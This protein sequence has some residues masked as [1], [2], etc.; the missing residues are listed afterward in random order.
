MPASTFSRAGPDDPVP[1]IQLAGWLFD[2][3]PKVGAFRF[4]APCPQVSWRLRTVVTKELG[5]RVLR[6]LVLRAPRCLG[7]WA[8]WSSGS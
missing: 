1:S 7:A 4:G 5:L 2:A 6:G 8:P 3:R